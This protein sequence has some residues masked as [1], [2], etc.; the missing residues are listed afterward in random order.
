MELQTENFDWQVLKSQNKRTINK[1]IKTN[2]KI[3][4]NEDYAQSLYDLYS[5][6]KTSFSKEHKV[7]ELCD[8]IDV[9]SVNGSEVQVLLS[10]YV[11][12]TINLNHE[13]GFLKLFGITQ[14]E[15]IESLNTEDGK[16]SVISNKCMVESGLPNIRVSLYQGHLNSIKHEFLSQIKNP[17]TAYYAVV[18]GKNHG[19][20]IVMVQGVEGFLPGSL[21]AANVVR[22]F[23]SMIGKTIPV[24]VEDYLEES[25]TFV[26]SNKKYLQKVLPTKIDKLE[27]DTQHFGTITGITKYGMFI[28]FDDIFTGLLHTSKMSNAFKEK[29]KNFEFKNG[30]EIEVWIKEITIDKKIILSDEDPS[31]KYKEFEEFGT[32][33]LGV[34]RGGEVISI[35][36]FGTLVKFQ[37]D[38]VGLISQKEL[39]MKNTKL[40]M[41][42]TVMVSID[43]IQNDKIYLSIPN[44]N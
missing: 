26:F 29:F 12:A 44:A 41:G 42:E 33:N 9:I 3:Y 25:N 30:D 28:E 24:M 36:P 23:D 39:K 4:C 40:S 37:K 31:I 27:I 19:G 16:L 22:D 15:F 34:I 10:S 20:F 13:K 7:G 18:T 14:D 2:A 17:I 1:S 43:K 5:T 38:I 32:K 35:Q 6:N 8:I 21:S 11:D